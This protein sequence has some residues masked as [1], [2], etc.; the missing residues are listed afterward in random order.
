VQDE[1]LKE[2]KRLEREIN[3]QTQ[4]AKVYETRRETENVAFTN[5]IQIIRKK[6]ADYERH[7]KKLKYHV[8]KED[9]DSL[10]KELQE[11]HLFEMDLGRLATEIANIEEEVANAKRM[12]VKL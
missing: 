1:Y 2:L 7:I 8:D 6:V 4:R 10:V 11:Q 9:T 12:K 5:D 3:A